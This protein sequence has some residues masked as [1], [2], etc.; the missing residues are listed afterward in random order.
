MNQLSTIS[1]EPWQPF[2]REPL[3][4]VRFSGETIFALSTAGCLFFKSATTGPLM[5]RDNCRDFV[6]TAV[7]LIVLSG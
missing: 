2:Q 5:L 3:R 7:D 6:L 4:K 1:F